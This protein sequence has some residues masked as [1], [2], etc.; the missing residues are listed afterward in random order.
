MDTTCRILLAF[1]HQETVDRIKSILVESGRNVLFSCTSGMQALRLAGLHDIEIAVVGFTLSD[2]PGAHFATDLLAG[3]SCSVLMIAPAEQ[4]P[5]IQQSFQTEDIVCLPRP[6]SSQ[7]LLTSI[8]LIM[9]YRDRLKH[10]RAE[11]RKLKEDLKRRS[12]ADKAK[13]ILMNALQLSEFEAWRFMQKQS[14]DTG[15]PLIDIAELMIEK[16]GQTRLPE[17]LPDGEIRLD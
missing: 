11:A 5:Y 12:L 1:R 16:Y 10:I 17:S 2:M 14:M 8:D 15:I 9:Q 7:S 6:V 3:H 13:T 4:I